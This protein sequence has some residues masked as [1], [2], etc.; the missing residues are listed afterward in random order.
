MYGPTLRQGKP[1]IQVRAADSAGHV[2][3]EHDA[4][5]PGPGDAVVVTQAGGGHYLG[6]DADAEEQDHHGAEELGDHLVAQPG[7]PR[8]R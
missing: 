6:H 8:M 1:R 2:D 7:F 4:Q 3:A 5:T